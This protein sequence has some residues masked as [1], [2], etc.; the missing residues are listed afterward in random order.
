[1]QFKSSLVVYLPILK[2]P[3]GCAHITIEPST[4]IG[5]VEYS[6]SLNQLT[7]T[8]TL[9]FH[10]GDF[11]V[12]VVLSDNFGLNKPYPFTLVVYDYPR[13]SSTVKTQVIKMN[14][15][16]TLDLP[17]IEEFT[18]ITVIF[19]TTL[20]AF[21]NFAYPTFTFSPAK[22]NDEGEFLI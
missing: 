13:F 17:I 2:D 10:L 15:E 9:P 4:L 5:F 6:Q 14:S 21:I 12:S 7:I 11:I 3:E 19:S 8:P 22:K 18:P 20:P 1:V 16:I